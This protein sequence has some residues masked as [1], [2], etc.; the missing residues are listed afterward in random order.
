M[1]F[2]MIAKLHAAQSHYYVIFFHY[3]LCDLKETAVKK[4]T[5]SPYE[6]PIISDWY[7]SHRT[8]GCSDLHTSYPTHQRQIYSPPADVSYISLKDIWCTLIRISST[9]NSGRQTLMNLTQ[10][11]LTVI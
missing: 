10:D 1:N 9:G 6:Y 11:G 5:I 7:H 2:Y 3:I 4:H 8:A